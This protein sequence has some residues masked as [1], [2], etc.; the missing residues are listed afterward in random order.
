MI[1]EGFKVWQVESQLPKSLFD[2]ILYSSYSK[3]SIFCA[4]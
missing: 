3:L 4:I 1:R 2:A